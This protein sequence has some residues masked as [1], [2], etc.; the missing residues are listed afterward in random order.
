MFKK[1]L[2]ILFIVLICLRLCES[3]MRKLTSLLNE[4]QER[5]RIAQEKDRKQGGK[6]SLG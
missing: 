1:Y 6:A 2:S 4:G 3:K 5:V